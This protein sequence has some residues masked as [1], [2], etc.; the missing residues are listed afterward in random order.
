MPAEIIGSRVLP[1]QGQEVITIMDDYGT[2]FTLNVSVND[3][4]NRQSHIDTA[5]AQ[6]TANE[7]ALEAYAGAH[8]IDLSAQKAAGITKRN[9]LKGAV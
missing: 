1:A 3:S 5:L 6:Q 2:E 4:A 9:A 7:A 8:G